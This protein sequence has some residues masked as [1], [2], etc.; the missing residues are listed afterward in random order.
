MAVVEG[1]K[2][3]G[4]NI[5]RFWNLNSLFGLHNPNHCLFCTYPS[6]IPNTLVRLV[7]CQFPTA[8][9]LGKIREGFTQALV[10]FRGQQ[11]IGR[12]E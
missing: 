6:L 12:E 4:C 10:N 5:V 11:I 2:L 7:S 8:I 3:S 9:D 1:I